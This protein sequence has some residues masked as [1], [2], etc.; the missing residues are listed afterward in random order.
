MSSRRPRPSTAPPPAS[1]LPDLAE[2]PVSVFVAGPRG[3]GKSTLV[4]HMVR[5]HQG[6][7]VVYDAMDEYA[8]A[9]PSGWRCYVPRWRDYPRSAQELDAVLGHLVVPRARKR[10]RYSLLVVEEAS[11]VA[12]SRRP[13]PEVLAQVNDL[14]RHWGLSAVYVARRPVQVH[15]D[16]VE[17]ADYLVLFR[18]GGL[19]DLRYLED[20]H[21]GL[22]RAVA[23]LQP[24]HYL[25]YNKATGE[26]R[27]CPPLPLDKPAQES[28]QSRH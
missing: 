7:G 21:R 16:L 25:L 8:E 9:T 2:R 11:R 24:Y 17:L 14:G 6:L 12:P 4:R 27:E 3:S 13:M 18:L 15:T 22:G 23:Q 19:N 10:I 20:L 5:G 28:L 1:P 26:W